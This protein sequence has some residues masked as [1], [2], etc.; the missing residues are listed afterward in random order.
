MFEKSI[1]SV[2]HRLG[3]GTGSARFAVV[4]NEV[5]K[6]RP[7]ICSYGKLGKV[8][9]VDR[10]VLQGDDHASAEEHGVISC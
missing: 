6:S 5:R 4:F 10:N 1:R 9:S 7:V 2:A 3:M 8:S